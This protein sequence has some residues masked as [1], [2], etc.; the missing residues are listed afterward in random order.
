MEEDLNIS[1]RRAIVA[2]GKY[3]LVLRFSYPCL[4]LGRLIGP[5]IQSGV[6]NRVIKL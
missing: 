5:N 4:R 6:V 3:E 1:S 2:V